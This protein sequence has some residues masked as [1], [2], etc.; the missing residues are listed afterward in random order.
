MNLL[1]SVEIPV[2]F[3][4]I[5][6]TKYRFDTTLGK[7]IT[8]QIV[9]KELNETLDTQ[10]IDI[11]LG[12]LREKERG[13]SHYECIELLLIFI[14]TSNGTTKWTCLFR[15][16]CGPVGS[17]CNSI[18]GTTTSDSAARR[19]PNPSHSKRVETPRHIPVQR[20]I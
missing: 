15:G 18:H 14:H 16:F 11:I 20:V 6:A 13:P 3:F 19:R 9:A 12:H 2:E 8:K 17:E 4:S 10:N 1:S 7:P 5:D